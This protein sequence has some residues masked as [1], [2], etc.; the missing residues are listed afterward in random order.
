MAGAGPGRGG[1]G[2][3]A[4]AAGAEGLPGCGAV[5]AASAGDRRGEGKGGGRAG[6]AVP[7]RAQLGYARAA[8]RGRASAGRL[9]GKRPPPVPG[10]KA[11]LPPLPQ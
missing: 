2:A 5:A 7:R 4:G 3:G 8:G 11:P 10:G 6:G 1:T 9:S